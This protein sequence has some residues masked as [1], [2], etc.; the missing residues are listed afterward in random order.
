MINSFQEDNNC[1]SHVVIFMNIF[2]VHYT[3][4]VLVFIIY[5]LPTLKEVHIALSTLDSVIRCSCVCV[6]TLQECW[7][8][9]KSLFSNPNRE[10]STHIFISHNVS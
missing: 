3:I 5:I 7:T 10:K 2:K 8:Q 4:L 9:W 1:Q 6:S